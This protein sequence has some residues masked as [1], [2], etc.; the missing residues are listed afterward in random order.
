MEPAAAPR[1]QDGWNGRP[2]VPANSNMLLGEE[3]P[4]AF[5]ATTRPRYRCHPRSVKTNA[6][7]STS[8]P[9]GGI[10]NHF[11]VEPGSTLSSWYCTT[12]EVS[13]SA[14]S[15]QLSV[16]LSSSGDH[17]ART[18]VGRAGGMVRLAVRLGGV[19]PY[20]FAATTRNS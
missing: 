17:E 7:D 3:S 20:S 9:S 15:V 5:R 12:Y 19:A 10:S 8:A 2:L 4:F 18:S 1:S 16:S 14:L 13:S 11:P 6:A